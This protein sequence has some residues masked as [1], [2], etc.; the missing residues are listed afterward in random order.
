[1][2]EEIKE[3][4]R[5]D[6]KDEVN[7]EKTA[8]LDE[9]VSE[10]VVQAIRN[11]ISTVMENED[12]KEL[13]NDD[14]IVVLS[15]GKSHIMISIAKNDEGQLF[16]RIGGIEAE[17]IPINEGDDIESIIA[18]KLREYESIFAFDAA[19][20]LE[21]KEKVEFLEK[22]RELGFLE[23]K[24]DVLQMGEEELEQENESNE[25]RKTAQA[26]ENDPLEEKYEWAKKH[27]T[28]LRMGREVTSSENTHMFF[29]DMLGINTHEIYRVKGEGT[30]E[31]SY[32][33]KDST[34]KII[35]TEGNET[36]MGTNPTR[37]VTVKKSDGTVEKRTMSNIKI[38]GGRYV[39]ISNVAEGAMT[40]RETTY[41]GQLTPD[42]S[43]VVVEA[44]D[45]RN[46]R[47]SGESTVKEGVA[48]NKSVYEVQEIA[49]S[50]RLAKK[51]REMTQ[52][53][54]ITQ[55]EVELVR[56]LKKETTKE[57]DVI[58][59]LDFIYDLRKE[60]I[61]DKDI[62]R[63]LNQSE[64]MVHAVVEIVKDGQCNSEQVAMILDKVERQNMPI[65]QAVKL[66]RD[67]VE[68]K[69]EPEEEQEKTP[70]GDAEDRRAGRR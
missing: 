35:E 3:E 39:L 61:K 7:K 66:V 54:R 46:N 53:D 57:C 6:V 28:P 43:I 16:V 48:R 56:S 38:F 44:L 17:A 13:M 40:G 33:G 62:E 5:E 34:G 64:K 24:E 10:E 65:E 70:W 25:E 11:A 60:G 12:P 67:G 41:I 15:D 9:L 68:E 31:F 63:L 49:E 20:V 29:K 50:A 37:E 58:H 55:E 18:A 4:L 42:G 36:R 30:H 32:I 1:M 21:G 23:R 69:E 51:I 22:K 45:S 27:G 2:E 52:D 19:T 8:P 26:G 47:A 14:D 59:F